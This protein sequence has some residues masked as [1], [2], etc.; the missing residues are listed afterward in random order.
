MILA[1]SNKRRRNNDYGRCVA[2]I[3]ENGKWIRLVADGTGDSLPVHVGKKLKPF[4][5]INANVT[6]APLK[7]QPE[8]AILLDYSRIGNYESTY[9]NAAYNSHPEQYIFG[10]LSNRLSEDEMSR[11][12]GS[13]RMIKASDI[14]IYKNDKESWKI[15]FKHF[16]H[17]G[18]MTTV[19]SEYEDIAM[20]DPDFYRV[21]KIG[22]ACI[23]LSLPSDK[24]GYSAYYKFVAA[25]HI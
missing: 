13:L 6:F 14:E 15:K 3:T 8:N 10:N 5:I 2:G 1:S 18:N 7:Y 17:D 23:V 19:L 9:F 25:I 11:I 12:N 21:K 22:A 24:G 16:K 20:T 4:L